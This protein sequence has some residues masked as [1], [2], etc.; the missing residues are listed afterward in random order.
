MQLERE[1]SANYDTPS[2]PF[3]EI[4]PKPQHTMRAVAIGAFAS[5]PDV[6]AGALGRRLASSADRFRGSSQDRGLEHNFWSWVVPCGGYVLR[7]LSKVTGHGDCSEGSTSPDSSARSSRSDAGFGER[8]GWCL[9]RT[10]HRHH[11]HALTR[12]DLRSLCHAAGPFPMGSDCHHCI[13][14]VLCTHAQCLRA[15]ERRLLLSSLRSRARARSQLASASEAI[16]ARGP[17]HAPQD[18]ET[19]GPVRSGRVRVHELHGPDRPMHVRALPSQ[20]AVVAFASAAQQLLQHARR[21]WRTSSRRM[22][23]DPYCPFILI[24]VACL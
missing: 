12:S 3:V 19:R 9:L 5:A 7:S 23:P 13:R 11:R 16:E 24:I 6:G 20:R 10:S 21:R 17:A 18:G 4:M 15:C 1:V 22:L 8:M 14:A 2:E